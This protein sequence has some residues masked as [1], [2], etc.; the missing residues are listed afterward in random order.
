MIV[1]NSVENND[2]LHLSSPH[3]QLV[4]SLYPSIQSYYI[5][6][7]IIENLGGVESLNVVLDSIKGKYGRL[8]VKTEILDFLYFETRGQINMFLAIHA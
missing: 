7:N 6:D 4:S 5:T 8:F 3:H 1:P 2:S